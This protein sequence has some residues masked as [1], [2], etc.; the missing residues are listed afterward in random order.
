M[1]GRAD[2]REEAVRLAQLSLAPLLVAALARQLGELDVDQGSNAFALGVARQLAR[3]RERR[4]DLLA[5][6]P[7]PSEPSRT[8][9]RTRLASVSLPGFPC[10]RAISSASRD[11]RARPL[12]VAEAEV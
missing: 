11:Q 3:A 8:R 4:L 6:A 10:A 2:L 12:R 7:R 9:A 1:A 5:R